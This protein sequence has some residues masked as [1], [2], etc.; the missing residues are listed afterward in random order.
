M[1]DARAAGGW[2]AIL[3]GDQLT[4]G[5][6]LLLPPIDPDPVALHG[7]ALHYCIA[8]GCIALAAPQ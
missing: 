8:V 4:G 5:V 2:A 6:Q 1:D 7:I 3:S